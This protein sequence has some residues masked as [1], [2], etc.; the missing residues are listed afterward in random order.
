MF[1]QIILI[2]AVTTLVMVSPGPDMMLVLRNTLLGRQH[3]GLQ[4]SAGI[5][6]GNLVHIS[7][8]VLGIGWFIS[9]SIVAYSVVRYAGAAYL[10]Y[11]GISSLRASSH[12]LEEVTGIGTSHVRKRWFVQGFVN[13]LLNPKGTMFYLGVF[14]TVI[15]PETS[16]TAMLVLVALMMFVSATFWLL[17]VH[18]L[19]RPLIRGLAQRSQPAV[20]RVSGALLIALGA[21]VALSEK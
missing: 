7:Y 21:R 6:A 13:N 19:D 8:C 3:A 5:L 16:P 4:T 1:D 10:I 9:R 14:T 18:T 15:T 2:V 20:N 17:F 12:T 11:L